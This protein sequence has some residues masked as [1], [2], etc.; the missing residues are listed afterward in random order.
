MQMP[1]S[2]GELG[3]RSGLPVAPSNVPG[4]QE[5]RERPQESLRFLQSLRAM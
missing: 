4:C 3:T 2:E 1:L 5:G